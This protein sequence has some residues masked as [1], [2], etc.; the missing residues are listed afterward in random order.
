M[1]ETPI[2][3]RKLQRLAL[4]TQAVVFTAVALFYLEEDWRGK[5]AWDA[6][7]RELEATG[8]VVDWE[9]LMPA[10]VPDDQNFFTASTNILIRFR[11]AQ[12]PAQID[13][14]AHLQW[15][16]L[17]WPDYPESRDPRKVKS[18]VVAE[19][20]FLPSAA[21]SGT[22]AGGNQA[23]NFNDPAA[24]FR[25]LETIEKA[26]G[27]S[28]LG[29]TGIRL[30]ELQLS[31]LAPVQIALRAKAQPAIS[32]LESFLS[33]DLVTILGRVQIEAADRGKLR[34]LLTQ[35]QVTS[36]ADY[37]KWSD[38]FIPAFDEI[39]DA[40]KRPYAILPG[41]YSEPYMIP[42][43]NFVTM[44]AVAQILAQRA[45]SHLLLRD[46]GTALQEVALIHDVCRILQKAPTG[47][48]ETLVEAMIN[49]AIAGLYVNTIA[50]G[51]R[52]NA[53][54]K[55]HFEALQ[56]QLKEISLPSWVAEAFR[57]ELAANER[58][59]EST[60]AY[61]IADLFSGTE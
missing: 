38:Q 48:P 32:D 4:I 42:I 61:K 44:R 54:Q 2:K 50:D 27:R 59:F 58:T 13:A 45:Q 7:K 40:L 35:V 46:P 10:P 56:D 3:G 20:N 39:R 19:L 43:P 22:F 14:A 8:T 53:W 28:L 16:P 60:P 37:L 9:K 15:L 57:D 29:A 6:C 34:I 55:P 1:N 47:K 18:L 52:L 36:A 11:K 31:N 33:S 5:R 26:V 21:A 12:T 17:S 23:A 24:R 25:V 30:S 49:V 41:E 51:L